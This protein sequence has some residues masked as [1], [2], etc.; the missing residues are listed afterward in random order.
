MPSVNLSNQ[1]FQILK[2]IGFAAKGDEWGFA[3][4]HFS[5]GAVYA[6]LDND[7]DMDWV[8]YNIDE[9]ASIYRNTAREITGNS[10]LTIRLRDTSANT[11]GVGAK[12]Y[13]KDTDGVQ[14]RYLSPSRGFQSA[15]S[16]ALHFGLGKSDSVDVTVVWPDG[17]LPVQKV[18]RVTANQQLWISREVGEP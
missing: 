15:V 2:G 8:V 9:P 10:F 3:A 4:P 6:D 7:G 14:Y 12:V 17:E 5:N 16:H 18:G 13:V 11:L 1:A